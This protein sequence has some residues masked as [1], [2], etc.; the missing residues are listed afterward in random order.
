MTAAEAAARALAVP[1]Q[2]D[3]PMGDGTIDNWIV[4]SSVHVVTGSLVL[5]TLVLA[6]AWV[7]RLALT[8]RPVDRV[9]VVLCVAALVALMVQALLGIKLLDQGSGFGQLYIH[10]LG[11][12]LPVGLLVLAGWMGWQRVGRSAWPLAIVVTAG[13]GSAMMAFVIGQAYVDSL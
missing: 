10:Y 2:Q 13:A 9:A 5:I 6:L 12:L 3:G 11:G 8:E 7:G 1:V 4:D